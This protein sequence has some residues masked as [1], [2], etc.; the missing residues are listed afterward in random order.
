MCYCMC[1]KSLQPTSSRMVGVYVSYQTWRGD[2]RGNGVRNCFYQVPAHEVLDR[3]A[4]YARKGH[5]VRIVPG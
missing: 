3:A 4:R 1:M 5:S 2:C